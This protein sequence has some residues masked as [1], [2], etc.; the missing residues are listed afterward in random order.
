M[1]IHIYTWPCIYIYHAYT[2]TA[3]RKKTP[4]HTVQSN[5]KLY[6]IR[7][8][9]FSSLNYGHNSTRRIGIQIYNWIIIKKI[10]FSFFTNCRKIKRIMFQHI[11]TRSII[12]NGKRKDVMHKCLQIISPTVS[13]ATWLRYLKPTDSFHCFIVLEIIYQ[14]L[15]AKPWNTRIRYHKKYV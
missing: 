2:M 13:Q 10:F 6:Q 1:S 4:P 12:I 14:M 11:K 9:S 8:T 5:P 15:Y 3:H 7:Q